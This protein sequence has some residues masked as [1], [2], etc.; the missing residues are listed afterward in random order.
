MSDIR[1]VGLSD[2]EEITINGEVFVRRSQ[3]AAREV[4]LVGL[5]GDPKGGAIIDG[6]RYV[7]DEF[8]SVR[9]SDPHVE[10]NVAELRRR[11]AAGLAKYG[12]D[13]TREDLTAGQWLQHLIEELLD[14]ANYAR[15]L[16]ADADK[17]AEAVNM[18]ALRK[19]GW[20]WRHAA[21]DYW[22]TLWLDGVTL[23]PRAGKDVIVEELYVR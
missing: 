10:D 14:A 5:N 16:K 7:A 18:P 13:L 12:K 3:S 6:K 19:V 20:R 8:S 1:T 9:C 15:R 4:S 11:A 22:T 21:S 2:M 23:P 17:A